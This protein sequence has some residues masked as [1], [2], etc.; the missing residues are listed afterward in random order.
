MRFEQNEFKI[1]ILSS[2]NQLHIFWLNSLLWS[3]KM[4]AYLRNKN[5]GDWELEL[6]VLKNVVLENGDGKEG[7]EKYCRPK[8]NQQIFC[9]HYIRF[10][11]GINISDI[12][13]CVWSNM[14]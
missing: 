8:Y 9:V 1:L 3:V 4:H 12:Y 7:M 13:F 11:F 14:T 2:I 5:K 6:R 10:Q